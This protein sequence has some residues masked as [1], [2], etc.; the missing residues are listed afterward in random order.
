MHPLGLERDWWVPLERFIAPERRL[1]SLLLILSLLIHGTGMALVGIQGIPG[2]AAPFTGPSVILLPPG[3]LPGA[4]PESLRLSLKLE[5]PS[6]I[7]LPRLISLFERAEPPP[8]AAPPLEPAQPESLVGMRQALPAGI[9]GPEA[10]AARMPLGRPHMARPPETEPVTPAAVGRILVGSGLAPRLLGGQTRLAT[11]RGEGA[12]LE[13]P[14][15][16]SI[17]VG[18]DGMVRETVVVVSSGSPD[19]DGEALRLVRG[20]KFSPCDDRETA[21]SPVAFYW[22]EAGPGS[23]EGP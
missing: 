4:G 1:F 23:G 22:P 14:T 3:E 11:L 15:V 20:L 5:D 12:A 13:G 21:W 17:G 18:P 8:P 9:G 19:Q 16:V 7:A 2:S 6:A 10:M